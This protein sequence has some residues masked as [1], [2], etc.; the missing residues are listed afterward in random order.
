MDNELTN[1]RVIHLNIFKRG[2]F[3][4][5]RYFFIPYE[6]ID[7]HAMYEVENGYERKIRNA[8]LRTTEYSFCK[9]IQ[10]ASI[11]QYYYIFSHL[12]FS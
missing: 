1:L 3:F 2:T 11:R 6:N 5:F 8:F 9:L 7:S 12:G 4:G 10:N